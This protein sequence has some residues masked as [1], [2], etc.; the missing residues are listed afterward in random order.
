MMVSDLTEEV[1]LFKREHTITTQARPQ[2][3]KGKKHFKDKPSSQHGSVE[4]VGRWI[5][6]RED[7]DEER[8]RE[9][10]NRRVYP[11]GKAYT[12]SMNA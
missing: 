2:Q 5:K 7:R 4:M 9:G 8:M 6:N 12:L 10:K 1:V 3:K 11:V